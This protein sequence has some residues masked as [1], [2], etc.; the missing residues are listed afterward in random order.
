MPDELHFSVEAHGIKLACRY[1]PGPYNEHRVHVS[2]PLAEPEK[3]TGQNCFSYVNGIEQPSKHWVD[4]PEDDDPDNPK[5]YTVW[6]GGRKIGPSVEFEVDLPEGRADAKAH[7]KPSN[8]PFTIHDPN[9]D[10]LCD[11]EHFFDWEDDAGTIHHS[12]PYT[13]FLPE[14]SA[15]V[16]EALAAIVLKNKAERIASDPITNAQAAT[17]LA[18]EKA[19]Q[20]GVNKDTWLPYVRAALTFWVRIQGRA[21]ADDNTRASFEAMS[22]QIVFSEEFTKLTGRDYELLRDEVTYEDIKELDSP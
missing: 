18:A 8:S 13:V 9:L 7:G 14:V 21:L 11:Y 10:I 1:W 2:V 15:A 5:N 16:A 3:A 20:F 6:N 22:Q 12:G 4:Y 17:E 19:R